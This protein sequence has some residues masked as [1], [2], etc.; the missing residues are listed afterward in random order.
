MRYCVLSELD[1]NG[2][3]PGFCTVPEASLESILVESYATDL[4]SCGGELDT[5]FEIVVGEAEERSTNF[6]GSELCQ[7]RQSRGAPESSLNLNHKTFYLLEI[8]LFSYEIKHGSRYDQFK[9]RELFIQPP[10]GIT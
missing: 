3:G 7:G 4:S 1:R 6:L 5:R 2:F 8:D 10:Q 9:L